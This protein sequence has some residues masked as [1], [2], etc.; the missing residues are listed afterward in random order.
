MKAKRDIRNPEND[1]LGPDPESQKTVKDFND[2]EKA[3]SQAMKNKPAGPQAG[4]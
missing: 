1:I 3:K 4:M 2:A